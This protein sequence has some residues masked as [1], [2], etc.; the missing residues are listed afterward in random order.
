VAAGFASLPTFHAHPEQLAAAFVA[1]RF[2][3]ATRAA[4]MVRYI[5]GGWSS[6]VELLAARATELGVSIHLGSHVSELPQP[7]VVVATSAKSASRLLGRELPQDGTSVALLD[8]AL[9]DSR[10]RWSPF[11]VLDLDAGT[12]VARYSAVDPGIARAG[13]HLVQASAPMR[14]AET[15][16][17]ATARLED[18]IDTI[19][20]GWKSACEWRRA[21]LAANATGAVDLPGRSWRDRPAIVQSGGLFL[22]GDYVASPGLLSEVSWASATEAARLATAWQPAHDPQPATAGRTP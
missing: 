14:V 4:P 8:V 15:H 2:R 16:R 7:P 11:A 3:R 13:T 5:V 9:R 20:P 21:S 17:E 6:L 12:Y 19:W 18:S 22:A 1:E 10:R